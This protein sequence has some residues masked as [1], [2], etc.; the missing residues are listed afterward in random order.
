MFRDLII[1]RQVGIPLATQAAHGR[2]P[3]LTVV[4]VR[5]H[6]LEPRVRGSAEGHWQVGECS[7]GRLQILGKHGGAGNVVTSCVAWLM[8]SGQLSACKWWMGQP[9]RGTARGQCA[10]TADC[11]LAVWKKRVIERNFTNPDHTGRTENSA[12]GLL[13]LEQTSRRTLSKGTTRTPIPKNTK[14]KTTMSQP[15]AGKREMGI[16][17]VQTVAVVL[18]SPNSHPGVEAK[19]GCIKR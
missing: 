19:L 15:S 8:L 3:K 7:I 12:E 13:N 6:P 16:V 9:E 11:S 1:A 10:C 4:E 14:N 2:G 18:D 17:W 5:G